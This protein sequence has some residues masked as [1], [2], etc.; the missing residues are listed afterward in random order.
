MIG[1]TFGNIDSVTLVRFDLLVCGFH[2]GCGSQ[3]DA[4][5]LMV[6]QLMIQRK[7]KTSSLVATQKL[8]VVSNGASHCIQIFEDMLIICF[9]FLRIKY[10]VFVHAAATKRK[11]SLWTSI[12][13]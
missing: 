13:M 6:S 7:A 9:D 10:L 1:Q 4:V 12:P 8:D 5:H 11:N 3:N 2:H